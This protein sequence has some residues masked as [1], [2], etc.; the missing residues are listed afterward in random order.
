MGF[1]SGFKVLN[2]TLFVSVAVRYNSRRYRRPLS[3]FYWHSISFA[4]CLFYNTVTTTG[5]T[6]N[7]TKPAKISNKNW[8]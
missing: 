1:N 5:V 2:V 6:Q 7:C 3:F 4:A 8:A